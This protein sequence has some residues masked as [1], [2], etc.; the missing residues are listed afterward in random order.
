MTYFLTVPGL[1]NSGPDH[2][3]TFFENSKGDFRRVLQAE[4]NA[5]D[6]RDWIV[7]IDKTVSTLDPYSVVLI[8]HSLG[9]AAIAFWAQR[10]KRVIKGVLPSLQLSFQQAGTLL[11]AG[12]GEDQ[13]WIA[14]VYIDHTNV[15]FVFFRIERFHFTRIEE[16]GRIPLDEFAD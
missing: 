9:C 1:G 15:S 5:P 14:A 7:T 8:G 6:C 12:I 2:W 11:D 16:A 3:Q 10:F 13:Q 4:W